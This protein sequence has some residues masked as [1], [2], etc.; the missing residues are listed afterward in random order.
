MVYFVLNYLCRKICESACNRFEF[1]VGIFYHLQKI[2]VKVWLTL[3]IKNKVQQL[4]MD[5]IN[6]ILKKIVL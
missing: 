3:K 2:G 1:I 4:F 6:S 5:I